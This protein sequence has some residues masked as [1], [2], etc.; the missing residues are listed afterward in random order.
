[1]S[2]G[3][4]PFPPSDIDASGPAGAL[5]FPSYPY[6]PPA[7]TPGLPPFPTWPPPSGGAPFPGTELGPIINPYPYGSPQ[8]ANISTAD[9]APPFLAMGYPHKMPVGANGQNQGPANGLP[10][11]TKSMETGPALAAT[12]ISA[13]HPPPIMGPGPQGTP[14]Y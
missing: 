11:M 7:N 5:S 13:I 4:T 2:N 9:P 1:M 8:G 14:P 10:P 6:G 12:W 3:T